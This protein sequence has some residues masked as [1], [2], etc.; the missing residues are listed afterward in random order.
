MIRK[1]FILSEVK[2][3]YPQ[4]KY[5]I[6]HPKQVVNRPLLFES[7]A[8]RFSARIIICFASELDAMKDLNQTD[9]LFLCIGQP[10]QNVMDA[11]DLC[12]LP[13][14]ES[15]SLLLNFV[16]RLFDRL[17]EW[18]QRLKEVAESS[19][20]VSALLDC[21]AGMLQN[22]LCLCDA[23]S[24]I[25][26]RAERYAEELSQSN[27]IAS[28]NLLEE[29]EEDEQTAE[30]SV[31][32]LAGVDGPE[33]AIS[34]FNAGGAQFALVCAAIERQ[35]YGSDE[36]VF[37]HLS[38]YVKLMLSE[39]KLSV[40][41]LRQNPK[42]DE[43]EPYL[44]ALL[45]K[46]TQKQG[47]LDALSAFGWDGGQAYCVAAA[48][49]QDGDMRAALLHTLCDRIESVVPNSCAFSYPP[50]VA[51][52]ARLDG[53]NSEA[54]YDALREICSSQAARIGVC[55]RLNGLELL[56]ERLLLASDTLRRASAAGLNFAAFSDIAEEYLCA[57]GVS[58]Y[59]T[60]LVCLRSVAEMAAYDNEH[61]TNYIETAE[62]YVKNRFNA[63]KTA[64]DLFI[65]RSTF[66]Y[67]LER[68]KAQFG[69]DLDAEMTSPLHLFFSLRMA[70]ENS[71]L[72]SATHVTRG[73]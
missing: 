24:H 54:C 38:G 12:V 29:A 69:L 25:I 67:R 2:Y 15:P 66:L 60:E 8:H 70:R 44:R 11:L 28:Y 17:D 71:R 5:A 4:A 10:Q 56:R 33:L 62:R 72:P 23:R 42:N 46:D 53:D 63:V 13:A 18:R 27:L 32:H 48:E 26:S 19:V 21:A 31:A 37:E 22:P 6:Q 57:R 47:V 49:A 65:H 41:A 43:I 1:E 20:D 35:F 3:R 14:T 9:P 52:V 55:E 40:R 16:Q 39:R 73:D 7:S 45:E 34:R 61:E 51:I 59:P 58:E 68:I 50:V 30:G 36:V 64:N